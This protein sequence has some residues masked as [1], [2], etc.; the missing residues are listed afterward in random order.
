MAELR[1]L[2]VDWANILESNETIRVYNWTT[3]NA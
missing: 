2:F 1:R 3:L